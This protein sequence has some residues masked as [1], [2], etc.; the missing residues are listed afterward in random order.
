MKRALLIVFSVFIA[1]SVF[2]QQLVRVTIT[3]KV[4]EN[5]PRYLELPLDEEYNPIFPPLNSIMVV[6]CNSMEDAQAAIREINRLSANNDFFV[7]DDSRFEY[8][9]TK[10]GGWCELVVSEDGF[11]VIWPRELFIDP[12]IEP[13]KFRENISLQISTAIQLEKI[14]V[15]AKRE[16]NPPPVSGGVQKGDTL[17]FR[18]SWTLPQ[19]LGKSTARLIVQPYLLHVNKKDTVKYCPPIICDGEEYHLTQY[20]RQ[21][22]SMTNDPLYGMSSD[23][24]TNKQFPIFGQDLI[25]T[26]VYKDSLYYI[27]MDV[28]IE[29]Y[30]KV[31]HSQTLWTGNTARIYRPL[32]HLKWEISP[33]SLDF[34]QFAKEAPTVDKSESTNVSLK[35]DINK[36]R[37]SDDDLESRAQLDGVRQTI[38]DLASPYTTFTKFSVHG[39]SSPDGRYEKNKVLAEQRSKYALKEVYQN[40]PKKTRNRFFALPKDTASVL[41]WISVADSLEKDSLYQYASEIREIVSKNPVMDRQGAVIRN[42]PYY[43]THITKYLDNMRKMTFNY[44]YRYKRALTK[45][46]IYQDYKSGKKDFNLYEYWNLLQTVTDEQELEALCRAAIKESSNVYGADHIWLLPGNILAELLIKRGVYDPEILSPYIDLRWGC[47]KDLNVM[48]KSGGFIKQHLNQPEILAN[49]AL[50]Y[51]KLKNYTYA[52]YHA[53]KLPLDEKYLLLKYLCRCYLGEWETDNNVYKAVSNSSEINKIVMRLARGQSMDGA[54]NDTKDGYN[55]EAET[56]IERYEKQLRLQ[57]VDPEQNPLLLYLKAI[58]VCRLKCKKG[59]TFM[60]AEDLDMLKDLLIKCFTLDPLYIDTAKND[61]NIPEDLMKI[62]LNNLSK[63]K[64]I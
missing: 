26:R 40:L 12:Y 36:T 5:D 61:P 53:Q 44:S 22:Y 46:E 15:T 33:F 59:L 42:L 35:F 47:N 64:E 14:E 43:R 1:A 6:A 9:E 52:Y 50:I 31:Y 21:G 18:Y 16:F 24:L 34:M 63:Q 10:D 17:Y 39:V 30:N 38:I 45:D 41:P 27:N 55:M 60:E 32:Q 2:G 25:D 57:G 56:E 37:I 11:L 13:V 7:L 19:G 29:D 4:D 48:T 20:R 8:R 49:Q 3:E 58:V 62:V 51:L 23:T 54:I 28:V